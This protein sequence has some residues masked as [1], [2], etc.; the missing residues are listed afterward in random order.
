MV[1]LAIYVGL[2]Y[3]Q[4]SIRVCVLNA[5][6][7]VLVNRDCANDPL[8]VWDLVAQFGYPAACALEACCGA[9]DFAE[10]QYKQSIRLYRK[11]LKLLT[12]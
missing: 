3:H 12:S 8:A 11:A 7:R 10:R 1:N 5:E 9:A 4:D 6:E 2:D